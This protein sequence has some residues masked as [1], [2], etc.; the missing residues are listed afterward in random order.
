MSERLLRLVGTVT[1][2]ALTVGAL[3]TT[4]P[5]P[6]LATTEPPA[7]DAPTRS[8]AETTD[9]TAEIPDES[10][11]P[12]GHSVAELLTDLR[13][14]HQEAEKAT[15]AYH[16]TG[17]ELRR[18]RAEVAGLD[19]RLAA[20]RLSLHDSRGAAGRLARQQYQNSSTALSPYVRLLMSRDPHRALEQ[21]HVI[22]QVARERAETIERLAGSEQDT[23]ALARRA[24]V[25]LDRQLTLAEQHRREH[26]T[27]SD[28]LDEIEKLLASLTPDQLAAVK[29]SEDTAKAASSKLPGPQ[30]FQGRGELREKPHPPAPA[31]EPAPSPR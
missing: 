18:Q 14:L 25:A 28:R 11:S 23:D 10:P 12:E 3:L 21:G 29:E 19:H 1:V 22:G 6:A 20:A 9:E 13:R 2:T 31:D 15:G 4:A 24:R 7:A 17:E 26:D 8:L 30:A 5:A 16:R 27:A